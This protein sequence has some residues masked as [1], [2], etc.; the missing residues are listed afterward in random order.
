VIYL[1]FLSLFQDPALL[2]QQGAQAMRERR[3][4]D[5]EKAYRQLV[6]VDS[7]NPAWR[8]NLGLT[9]YSAGRYADA[10]PELQMFIQ[11]KPQAGPSHLLL[12]LS[13]LKLSQPCEAVAPLEKARSWNAEQSLIELADAYYGCRRFDLAGRTYEAALATKQKSPSVAR[14]AAHCY[15]EA[16]AYVDAQRVFSTLV[17][18]FADAADFNYEY[19]DTLVRL[20]GPLVG[21][22]YLEKAVALKPDL[23]AAR[24]ELGKALL[25][26]ER[27]GQA[28]VHLELAARADSALLLPLSRAYRAAGRTA[29][30]DR[31]MGEYRRLV[32]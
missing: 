28:I 12:G 1:L 30:A 26:L 23:L 10:I 22:Y 16:R 9:L 4:A 3:F 24:G 6:K 21:L 15:W 2:S 20:Q 31:V 25:A 11:A 7:G 18:Q 17:A 19:G 27:G 29:D 13:R 5:A 8:M 32:R 14:Q